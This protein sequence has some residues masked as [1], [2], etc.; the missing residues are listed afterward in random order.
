MTESKSGPEA[1]PKPGFWGLL[2]R[3]PLVHFLAAGAIIFAVYAL[4][5]PATPA[6]GN[7]RVI[8]LTAGDLAQLREGWIAQWRRPPT[9]EELQG[10]I[11]N[12]IREEILSREALEMGLDRDDVI[13]RRRLAQKYEFLTQDLIEGKV[14]GDAE[15]AATFAAHPERYRI[16]G[17]V[18]FTQVFFNAEEPARRALAQLRAGSAP[19]SVG[20]PTLLEAEVSGRREEEV[21]RQFGGA[22]MEGIS[23]AEPGTWTGPVR[24]AFGWHAVRIASRRRPRV[25]ELSEVKD[26]VARDWR[27][28]QRR[29]LND[30]LYQALKRRYEISIEAPGPSKPALGLAGEPR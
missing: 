12:R 23:D 19:G 9:A 28:G 25:P 4:V 20:D 7:S 29:A 2:F 16:E 1:T 17:S 3:E 21:A 18:S 6:A 24:S 8:R 30:G 22:F 13:V 5:R 11:D 15:L 26:A 27:D 14:A 10:L